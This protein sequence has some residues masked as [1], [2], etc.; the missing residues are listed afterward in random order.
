[1]RRFQ[2]LAVAA[3]VGLSSCSRPPGPPPA[4]PATVVIVDPAESMKIAEPTKDAKTAPAPIPDGG[5][6]SF[7]DDAGGKA[8]AKTLTPTVPP[9]MST[10]SPQGPRDRKLPT[11]L[12][13]PAPRAPDP[14]SAPPRLALAP[15]RKIRPVPL[16]DRVPPDIG[17]VMPDLPPR[18]DYPTGPLVRT[19]GRDVSKPAELPLLSPKLVADRAPLT[20]PTADFTASSVFGATLPLRTEPAGFVRINLPDPFENLGAAKVRTP[21][22]EDPNRVLP[23]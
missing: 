21:V 17:G 8:L 12:D 13:A 1:V 22:S 2:F 20:D 18:P 6:F 9:A 14:A 19:V 23:R 4:A 3:A 5:S 15:I 10:S 16:P 7:P 11:Y